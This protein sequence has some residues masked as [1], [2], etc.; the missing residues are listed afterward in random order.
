MLDQMGTLPTDHHSDAQRI[1]GERSV[2]LALTSAA[3]RSQ[4]GSISHEGP[5]SQA[6]AAVCVAGQVRTFASTAKH[7]ARLGEAMGGPQSTSNARYADSVL[8]LNLLDSGNGGT[9]RHHL[10]EIRPALRSVRAATWQLYNTS[11]YEHAATR[12]RKACWS[13][14]SGHWSHHFP[15][16]WTV[17]QCLQRALKREEACGQRY[18][19]VARARPD[20]TLESTALDKVRAITHGIVATGG[21]GAAFMPPGV[22]GDR[23]F[24]LSRAAVP[25]LVEGILDAFSR[26]GRLDAERWLPNRTQCTRGRYPLQG[27]E[28]LI[29]TVLARR[30]VK[31]HFD[32]RLAAGLLRPPS[33]KAKGSETMGKGSSS[34]ASRGLTT[35]AAQYGKGRGRRLAD[36]RLAPLAILM[37]GQARTLSLEFVAL[38]IKAALANLRS[39][40]DL[41]MA[42]DRT[43][44][45]QTSAWHARHPGMLGMRDIVKVLRPLQWSIANRSGGQDVSLV[46]GHRLMVKRERVRHGEYTWVMRLRPDMAYLAAFPRLSEWPK[47]VRPTLFADY[48]SSGANGSK[49]GPTEKIKPALQR[50][51]GICADDTFAFMD[52][53]V[54]RRYFGHWY[55]NAS[56]GGTRRLP[57]RRSH[58]V[59]RDGRLGCMECRLGCTMHMAAVRVMALPVVGEQRVLVRPAGINRT[60]ASLPRSAMA[61]ME[62]AAYHYDKR[63]HL[64]AV[65]GVKP[66]KP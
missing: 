13:S 20:L 46:R 15:Q 32:A 21:R 66:R 10:S 33:P 29:A 24:V 11:D 12:A 30:G 52:R 16:M 43:S 62:L 42:V 47:P 19:F 38:N 35:G 23:F 1:G 22:G 9:A 36:L 2:D 34:N 49:C 54:A 7:L 40:S 45:V 28:C 58:P 61:V 18:G 8:W 59:G 56:C 26:C 31:L 51:H 60:N 57:S 48:I 64:R 55:W 39:H 3:S 6:H 17:V 65:S 4:N 27:T 25:L 44:M 53:W 50:L 63:G 14:R 37:C 41:F 5:C